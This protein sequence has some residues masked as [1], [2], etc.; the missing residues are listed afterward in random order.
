[1]LYDSKNF[2]VEVPENWKKVSEAN[3]SA[4]FA[5]EGGFF[6]RQNRTQF[7]VAVNFNAVPISKNDLRSESEKFYQAILATNRY[8]EQKG[9][10]K[11]VFISGNKA[12]AASFVGFNAED[13]EEELVH[14]YTAF[15]KDGNL[16]YLLTV[17]PFEQRRQYKQTLNLILNSI[18]HS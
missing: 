10:T 2:F 13:Q 17:T 12:L 18:N 1:V 14:I 4:W 3:D 7:R 15:T 9:V 6:K 11:E 8:L 16:F 5:P